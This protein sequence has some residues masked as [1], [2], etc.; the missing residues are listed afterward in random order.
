MVNDTN[1]NREESPACMQLRAGTNS[2]AGN[3]HTR[4]LMD[5]ERGYARSF[6]N[7]E[8]SDDIGV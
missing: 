8:N 4:S 3:G 6:S 2:D 5:N 7:V 1:G